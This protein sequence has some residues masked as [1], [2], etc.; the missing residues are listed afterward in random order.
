MT[1]TVRS[2]YRLQAEQR[3]AAATLERRLIIGEKLEGGGVAIKDTDVGIDHEHHG[4][5]SIENGF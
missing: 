3:V 4:R 1:A 2:C 5:V